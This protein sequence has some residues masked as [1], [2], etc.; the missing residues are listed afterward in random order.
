MGGDC[1]TILS[2]QQVFNKHKYEEALFWARHY[3]IPAKVR[4]P[5][6]MPSCNWNFDRTLPLKKKPPFTEF[7]CVTAAMLPQ[8]QF[9]MPIKKDIPEFL[10]SNPPQTLQLRHSPQSAPR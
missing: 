1:G 4:L 6:H 3:A 10:F 7:E 5:E 8:L 2:S 9:G